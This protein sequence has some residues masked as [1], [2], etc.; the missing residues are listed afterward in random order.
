MC[1]A[2]GREATPLT[3]QGLLAMLRVQPLT[4]SCEAGQSTEPDDASC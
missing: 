4:L 2:Y 1:A 3:R